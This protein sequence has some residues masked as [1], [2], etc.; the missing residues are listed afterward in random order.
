MTCVLLDDLMPAYDF[1]EI[2][3]VTIRAT[4]ERIWRALHEVT[5]GDVPG[6]KLLF[7]VRMLPSRLRGRR[8]AQFADERSFLAQMQAG[9]F[10]LLGEIP[11]QEL[12]VGVIGQFWRPL[13]ATFKR[14]GDAHEFVAENP[15]NCAK[16]AM[17]F[18]LS[19]VAGGWRLQTET[20][21]VTPD[22]ATRRKFG[23]Y[24]RLIATGSALIRRLWLRAVRRRAERE[25]TGAP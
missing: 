9:S 23:V 18:S 12:V 13:G 25:I 21:I 11:E 7:G 14:I 5:P 22:R 19:E 6:V 8:R 20:R 16:S 17:N 3:A 4:P 2:H 1:C 15:P 10:T 24:W